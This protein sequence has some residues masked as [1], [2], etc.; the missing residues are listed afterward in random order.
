MRRTF[1]LVVLSLAISSFASAAGWKKAYFGATKPGKVH[2][3]AVF[4]R[5][6]DRGIDADQPCVV[7][8]VKQAGEQRVMKGKFQ[9]TTYEGAPLWSGGAPSDG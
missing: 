5:L 1:L 8:L 6:I 3:L 4:H 2:L 7:R 9:I